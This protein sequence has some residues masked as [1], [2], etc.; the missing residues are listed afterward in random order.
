[1]ETTETNAKIA[2]FA[3]LFPSISATAAIS[4]GEIV[5]SSPVDSKPRQK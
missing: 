2:R 4:N 3:M 1:L 5:K